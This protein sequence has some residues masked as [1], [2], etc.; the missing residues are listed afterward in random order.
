MLT[1]L[2]P[3]SF[4]YH[5][6]RGAFLPNSNVQCCLFARPLQDMS[7]SFEPINVYLHFK[8]PLF[9]LELSTDLND[10]LDVLKK[11]IESSSDKNCF[12]YL[13]DSEILSTCHLGPSSEQIIS[14]QLSKTITVD[15]IV[16]FNDI[17]DKSFFDSKTFE[18]EAVQS[19]L[20]SLETCF[21]LDI[22]PLGLKLTPRSTEIPLFTVKIDA[23]FNLKLPRF[24]YVF[25][26]DEPIKFKDFSDET[27]MLIDEKLLRRTQVI[28][29]LTYRKAMR[30]EASNDYNQIS[31]FKTDIVHECN[32]LRLTNEEFRRL[33]LALGIRQV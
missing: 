17:L 25:V 2:S 16:T 29:D 33:K 27:S 13:H 5:F 9:A 14:M 30:L 23:G 22:Y 24:Y 7:N 31:C 1:L 12:V 6:L 32:V 11:L 8:E 19:F 10:F 18:F 15:P 4:A 26:S 20:N 3:S 21:E 28:N